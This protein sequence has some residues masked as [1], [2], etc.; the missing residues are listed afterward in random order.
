[1]NEISSEPTLR[2]MRLAD[3]NA[4]ESI[5]KD[6]MISGWRRSIFLDC[7]H[8]QYQCQCLS[9]E[10]PRQGSTVLGY[11]IVNFVLDECHI[12]NIALADKYQGH[13]YGTLMMNYLKAQC[14]KERRSILLLEVRAD[15]EK[16]QAFYR[17]EGFYENGLRANYY[18]NANGI[19]HQVDA[20][21]MACPLF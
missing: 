21:L 14:L 3:L 20:V 10:D 12:L 17:R 11:L 2:P 4:V 6:V 7:L 18:P 1:M 5:E 19:P 13:G 16:A 8:G 15:N 9:I